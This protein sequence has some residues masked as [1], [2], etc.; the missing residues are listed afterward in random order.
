MVF[1]PLPLVS[2][3]AV[4]LGMASLGNRP[5]REKDPSGVV[6][7]MT[8]PRSVSVKAC[9]LD[10]PRPAITSL[11]GKRYCLAKPSRARHGPARP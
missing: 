6:E 7:L 1:L 5:S 3:Q 10:C 11:I 8:R 4:I 2:S 9:L